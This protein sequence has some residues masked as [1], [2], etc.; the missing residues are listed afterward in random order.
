LVLV[1]AED[2]PSPPA[3]ARAMA[4]AIPGA[5][6]AEVAAAGHLAPLEQPFVASRVISDFLNGLP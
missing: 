4:D 6:Y 5:R 3:V 2:V 1:G